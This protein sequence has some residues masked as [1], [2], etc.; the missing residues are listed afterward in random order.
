MK[1]KN[2][3]T[4]IKRQRKIKKN[5]KSSLNKINTGNPKY[6]KNI[7]QMQQKILKIFIIQD[8]KLSI[9]LM[10]MLKLDLK[11]CKKL[12]MAQELKH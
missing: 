6:I 3:N 11:L 9:Y 7:N 1:Q 2:D 10:I 8:K 12:N 4:A 5:F